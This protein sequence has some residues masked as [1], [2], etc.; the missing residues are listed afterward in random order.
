MR[1]LGVEL[2][3]T[4]AGYVVWGKLP[5][6]S[7]DQTLNPPI[8]TI[9][10]NSI[11]IEEPVLIDPPVHKLWSWYSVGISLE[12][13]CHLEEKAIEFFK[14]TV[15]KRNGAYTI[16]LPFKTEERPAINYGLAV[17]QLL[18]L[19][20][21]PR[22]SLYE[23]YRKIH[24]EYLRLG[25]METVPPGPEV[26][27]KVHYLPHHPVYKNSPT[28]PVRRVFNASFR[29]RK[30]ALSLNDALYSGSNLAQKIQSV[31]IRFREGTYGVLANI[32]KAF[33]RIGVDETDRDF[34]RFLFFTS[35]DMQGVQVFR[36]KV[37]VFSASCSP[38][39][40][41]QTIEHH[42]EKYEHPLATELK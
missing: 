27:G 11:R 35:P 7:Q 19:K 41:N 18:S 22:P 6:W 40:L 28:T 21:N 9:A 36:F 24:D 3:A 29:A 25:F 2:F 14:S 30:N 23:D 16:R 12:K 39:L 37:V 34:C 33:L 38:Y 31:I 10:L 4:P 13:Y 5:P 42:L 32:S 15:R 1:F 20:R 17:A 26:N 8:E